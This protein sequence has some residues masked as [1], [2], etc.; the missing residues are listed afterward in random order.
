V[1]LVIDKGLEFWSALELSRKVVTRV[2]F[3]TLGLLFLAYLPCILASALIYG[4]GEA[5]SSNDT[6]TALQT[7]LSSNHPDINELMNVLWTMYI[8][9]LF[10]NVLVR[11]F[12]ILNLP[13]AVGATMYAYEDLFGARRTPSA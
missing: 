3:E 10:A 13:F 6:A 2:W 4:V 1:P 12:V 11:I 8:K 7:I 9:G 5:L